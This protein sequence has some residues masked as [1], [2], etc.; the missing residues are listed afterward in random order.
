MSGRTS[1]A[2]TT[3]LGR[4]TNLGMLG[5]KTSSMLKPSYMSGIKLDRED[6]HRKSRKLT[7]PHDFLFSIFEIKERI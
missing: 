6:D 1:G 2:N 7:Y 5:P 3:P 4:P